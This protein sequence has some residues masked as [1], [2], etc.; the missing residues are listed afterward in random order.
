MC[1]GLYKILKLFLF[2]FHFLVIYPQ[3]SQLVDLE[4]NVVI[5]L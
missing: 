3:T 1:L 4:M 5:I 2:N